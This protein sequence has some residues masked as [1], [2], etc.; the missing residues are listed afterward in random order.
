MRGWLINWEMPKALQVKTLDALLQSVTYCSRCQAG[1]SWVKFEWG[2]R[3][4]KWCWSFSAILPWGIT[5]SPP[6]HFWDKVH[7]D[8]VLLIG[9]LL[10]HLMYIL[11]FKEHD[12]IAPKVGLIPPMEAVA[13]SERLQLRRSDF[14]VDDFLS[15]SETVGYLWIR[16]LEMVSIH[17]FLIISTG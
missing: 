15:V 10:T 11:H 6:G 1:L 14:W 7:R 9:Y 4:S 3:L 12:I 8:S 16:S 13:S 17:F 2:C 5:A